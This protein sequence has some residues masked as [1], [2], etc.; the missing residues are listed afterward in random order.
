MQKKINLSP[1]AEQK[2][3]YANESTVSSRDFK[4]LRKK[5]D[6][7]AASI[8]VLGDSI[9]L[10]VSKDEI[11]NQINISTEGIIIQ[12]NRLNLSGLVTFT[13]LS[14]SGQTTING[15]NITTGTLSADRINANSLSVDKLLVGTS[16]GGAGKIFFGSDYISLYG[17]STADATINLISGSGTARI[18]AKGNGGQATVNIDS[19]LYIDGG[20]YIS[21]GFIPRVDNAYNIGFTGARWVDVWAVDGTINTSDM[22]D[23][24]DIVV[25]DKSVD[26]ILK[27][28]P[29]KFKWK[30]KKR[31]HFG[32]LAQE[33]KEALDATVGDVG[34]YID[35]SVEG[36]EGFK[37]LRYSEFISPMVRTLQNLNERLEKLEHG[38]N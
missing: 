4:V 14:T 36:E 13:N 18:Y 16:L 22:M 24:K 31:Y 27:L 7:T 37:G 35:P 10:K 26:F 30:N 5:L 23:K 25:E 17:N 28:K 34:I 32:F 38:K 1:Q 29:V 20:L 19:R 21:G 2:T 12:A 3:S 15:G 33:V 9:N 11:I 8:T 6:G